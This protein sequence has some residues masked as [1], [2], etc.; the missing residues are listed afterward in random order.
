MVISCALGLVACKHTHSWSDKWTSDAT[1]HWHS[2]TKKGCE[3]KGSLAKHTFELRYNESN[4]WQECKVCGY[5]KDKVAHDFVDGSC[6]VCHF[7]YGTEDLEFTLNS[8]GK[9]YKVTRLNSDFDEAVKEVIIPEYFNGKP[10]TVIGENVFIDRDKLAKVVLPKTIVEIQDNAFAR[11]VALPEIIIPNSVK[12]IGTAV[13]EGCN[14]ITIKAEAENKPQGWYTDDWGINQFCKYPI[15]WDCNNN[16]VAD[17]GYVYFMYEEKDTPGIVK[18]AV[19]DGVALVAKQPKIIDDGFNLSKFA[20]YDINKDGVSESFEVVGLEDY[21]F[22]NFDN[23]AGIDFWGGYVT[24]GDYAFAG[25]TSLSEVVWL[26]KTDKKVQIGMCAFMGASRLTNFDVP[27]NLS[28]I[29][30]YAFS[31][32]AKLSEITLPIKVDEVGKGAFEDC[33]TLVIKCE[34]KARPEGWHEDWN[35]TNCQVVWDCNNSGESEDGKIVY[36][37]G[38]ATYLLNPETKTAKLINQ[39]TIGGEVEISNW[40]SYEGENYYVT[41]IGANVFAADSKW[42]TSVKI[43][44][45]VEK[46]DDLAFEGCEKLEEVKFNACVDSQGNAIENSRIK[47][48]GANAFA[49]CEALKTIRYEGEKEDWELVQKG[50]KW[51]DNTGD[52]KIIFADGSSI[53]KSED[54]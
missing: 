20:H 22:Y 45:Y 12:T 29:G 18:Y 27:E 3:E 6:T 8:D 34:A 13:F 15:V 32:C 36:E 14:G 11:C 10:V 54:K 1:S 47:Q 40:I 25:C 24:I 7:V 51:N 38:A 21:A 42:V 33:S 53:D 35:S 5:I 26:G 30:G 16:E 41:E 50:N 39:F 48:I 4:H 19:K 2:C 49:N 23:L 9:S 52:Y 17:N 44:G 37:S 46:I 43:S 31:G 28:A